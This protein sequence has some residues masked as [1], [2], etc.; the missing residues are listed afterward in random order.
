MILSALVDYYRRQEATDKIA[1]FGFT[2]A[3]IH[4]AIVLNPD[5]TLRENRLED[6]Q[7]DRVI[8]EKTGKTRQIPRSMRLP[9]RGGRS[10]TKIF[11]FFMWDNTG[12]VLGRD[13]KG[14]P[15]RAETMFAAFRDLHLSLA[16]Q[17]D[18]QDYQTVCEFLKNWN[19]ADAEQL[20][21][22]EQACGQNVVFRIFRDSTRKWTH[23]SK[24]VQSAWLRFLNEASET[25]VG[26]SLLSGKEEPLARLHPLLQGV[27]GANTMGAAIVSF[28]AAAYESYGKAQS[29][30]APVGELDAFRYTTA[31]NH[32]LRD[33]HRRIRIGDATVVFWSEQPSP[34]EDLFG[35]VVAEY[36]LEDETVLAEVKGFFSALRR[37][38]PHGGLP[39]PET[40]FYVL[41]L[42]PNASRLSI[43]FWLEGT[44]SDFAKRLKHHAD[45]LE[46]VG[47]R[48][49][50]PPL[51]IRR[52]LL[53]TAREPK[54]IPPQLAGQVAAA[55]LG[56]GR[57]PESLYTSVIRRIRIDR[58]LNHRR[59]AILKACLV[60]AQRVS[61]KDNPK[62]IPVSLN[63][64]HQDT[65]YHLGRLFAALEK[66]QEDAGQTNKTIRDGYYGSASA[67]PASVFP[68]IIR[69]HQYH[70]NKLENKGQRVR[71]EQLVQEICSHI[72]ERF[73][74]HL[75]LEDQGLFH[76]GYYHQRQ[77]FFKKR[78][79]APEA[80]E[81]EA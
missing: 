45:D 81:I 61:Q 75:S 25:V 38:D 58:Q 22:W 7:V 65:A 64:D 40:K 17:I 70:L 13:N 55:V 15:D 23:E 18:D 36:G 31:L 51:M 48:E 19:P 69:M 57:Y 20:E 46:M 60:R 41:G 77:D 11:P 80:E 37:G 53:E 4:F 32:L 54:E 66:T 44:V 21:N 34:F 30:N 16:G 56:G 9:D 42:S 29:Y 47:G 67:M 43:R 3:G 14:K 59:A 76:I 27:V 6:I 28:N 52:L 79:T 50:D 26:V 12:Y 1:P 2:Q 24:A 49:S 78:E 39:G 35:N 63:V 73:P 33:D 72:E 74:G 5:G 68:K 62:E 10:G 71:R 8:N